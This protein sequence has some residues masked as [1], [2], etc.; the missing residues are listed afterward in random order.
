MDLKL[1][2]CLGDDEPDIRQFL[3]ESLRAL[4]HNVVGIASTGRELI[5]LCRAKEPD[6]IIADIKMPEMDGIE[7]AKLATI[8]RPA[9]VVLVSGHWDDELRARALDDH[10]MAYLIKP[11]DEHD[12]KTAIPVAMNAFRRYQALQAEAKLLEGAIQDRKVLERAKGIIMRHAQ[13]SEDE[14]V[15]RLKKLALDRGQ[16]VIQTAQ[17]IIDADLALYPRPSVPTEERKPRRHGK[18]SKSRRPPKDF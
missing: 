11:I 6:L 15:H 16:N 1:K 7:A 12:L 5:E 14:A 18:S 4:G 8:D 3:V 10:I 2:I 17:M 13:L 9:P